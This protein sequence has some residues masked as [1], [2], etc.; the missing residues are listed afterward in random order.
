VKSCDRAL[1][2]RVDDFIHKYLSAKTVVLAASARS[3]HRK[4]L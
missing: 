2:N 3:L 4:N 1:K